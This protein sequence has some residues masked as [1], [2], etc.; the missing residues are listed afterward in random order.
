MF[1][2]IIFNSGKVI[3]LIKELME[4]IYLLNPAFHLKTKI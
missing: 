1:N 4:L 2:G 3:K